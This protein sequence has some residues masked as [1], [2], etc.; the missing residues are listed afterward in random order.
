MEAIPKHLARTAFAA[1]VW[2]VVWTL[3]LPLDREQ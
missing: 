1:V 3:D 2:T